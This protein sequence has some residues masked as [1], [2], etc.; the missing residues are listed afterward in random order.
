[1][2]QKVMK[3]AFSGLK[4]VNVPYNKG[5]FK[6]HRALLIAP[7]LGELFKNA[8]KEQLLTALFFTSDN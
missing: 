6:C 5:E 2:L 4:N 3:L 8:H 7:C 1:M